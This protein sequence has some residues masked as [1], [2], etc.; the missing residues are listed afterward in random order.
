MTRVDFYVLPDDEPDERQRFAC[1][2]AEKAF[3][4]GHRVYLHAADEAAAREIDGLLW[5]FRKPSF[6]PHGLLGSDDAGRIG[7]GWGQDPGEHHDVMINLDLAVPDFVGRFERVLE[8]VV[9]HPDI[10][11]P[12][13]ESWKRYKHY[14]YP[15]EKRDL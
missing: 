14:G 3:R 8:I 5:G 1:R 10:R 12:L 7:I 11:G 2:L 6:L 9:Q 4:G 13:R 15:I